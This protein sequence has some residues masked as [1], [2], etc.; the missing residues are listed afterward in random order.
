M[1]KRGGRSAIGEQRSGNGEMILAGWAAA[2]MRL[3]EKNGTQ[4]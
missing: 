3:K 2:A 4:R 1:R